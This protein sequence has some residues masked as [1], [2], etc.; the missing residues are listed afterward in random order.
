MAESEHKQR[1]LVLHKH[2]DELV[3]DFIDQ[4]CKLLSETTV[5]DLIKWSHQQ[6]KNPTDESYFKQKDK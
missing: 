3:A 6:T 1:H 2:L 4:T 5:M